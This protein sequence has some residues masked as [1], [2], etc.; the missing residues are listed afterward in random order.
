G[1]VA[2]LARHR[3]GDENEKGKGGCQEFLDQPGVVA[4]VDRGI[5]HRFRGTCPLDRCY[6]RARTEPCRHPS[7]PAAGSGQLDSNWRSLRLGLAC[8]Y[9]CNATERPSLRAVGDSP[10]GDAI[11]IVGRHLPEWRAEAVST[12]G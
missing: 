7:P 9:H 3:G 6:A 2:R 12:T 10:W 11:A 1:G 4:L 5:C 8:G